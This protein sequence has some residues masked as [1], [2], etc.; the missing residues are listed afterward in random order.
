MLRHNNR[1]INDCDRKITCSLLRNKRNLI[2]QTFDF[3]FSIPDFGASSGLIPKRASFFSL[4][5]SA[6][7]FSFS[8]CA[9]NIRNVTFN[10]APNLLLALDSALFF[11]PLESVSSILNID[12]EPCTKK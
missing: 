7:S 8:L 3:I 10:C 5:I 1:K 12:A 4:S 11:N 2:I 6:S 9:R